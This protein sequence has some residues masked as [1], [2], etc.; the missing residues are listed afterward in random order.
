MTMVIVS[1][2]LDISVGSIAGA[3][4]VVCALVV[5]QLGSV[6]G[7]IG[8]G[9]AI[10]LVLGLINP[11]IINYLQVNAA[12]ATLATFSACR[13]VAFLIAPEGTKSGMWTHNVLRN[14]EEFGIQRLGGINL[15]PRR[16]SGNRQ[17]SP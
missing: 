16:D 9:M 12:V 15:D 5:S 17:A 13:G 8:A 11:L 2:G 1:A 3:A 6:A 10:G 14:W 7:G 4:S